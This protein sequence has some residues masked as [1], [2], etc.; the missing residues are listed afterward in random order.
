MLGTKWRDKS[1]IMCAIIKKLE[2]PRL[3]FELKRTREVILKSD[4]VLDCKKQR[5][6]SQRNKLQSTLI[7]YSS[8]AAAKG[9][10]QLAQID[11]PIHFHISKNTNTQ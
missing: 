2:R 6:E 3:C 9:E 4:D 7:L 8:R 1:E 5:E 10:L 11:Q